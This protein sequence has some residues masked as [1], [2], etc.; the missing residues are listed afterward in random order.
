MALYKRSWVNGVAGRGK[1]PFSQS[2]K[3]STSGGRGKSVETIGVAIAY[4]P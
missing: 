1:C 2:Q 4:T 3:P